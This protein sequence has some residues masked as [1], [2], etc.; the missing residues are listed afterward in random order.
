[1][2]LSQIKWKHYGAQLLE[3]SIISAIIEGIWLCVDYIIFTSLAS[4]CSN[5]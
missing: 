3:K 1:M 2:N 5:T 4:F